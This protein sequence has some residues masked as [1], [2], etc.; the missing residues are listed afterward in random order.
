LGKL[1]REEAMSKKLPTDTW[2]RGVARQVRDGEFYFSVERFEMANEDFG[3]LTAIDPPPLLYFP[4]TR[5][6]WY[7]R[8]IH[9]G[10]IAMQNRLYEDAPAGSIV[11]MVDG[12]WYY[13]KREQ[14]K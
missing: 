7:E 5:M 13:A 3:E 11:V 6:W 9:T 14:T 10:D 4:P 2:F 8:E 12:V 1:A